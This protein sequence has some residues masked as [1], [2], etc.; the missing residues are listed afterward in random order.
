MKTAVPLLDDPRQSSLAMRFE[1][2]P[3]TSVSGIFLPS[4][5]IAANGERTDDSP[6]V[7]GDAQ[8]PHLPAQRSTAHQPLR[9]V[10][11]R[12]LGPSLFTTSS[13]SATCAGS[14]G[15]PLSTEG[16]ESAPDDV[17]G[18]LVQDSEA[19]TNGLSRH[20]LDA[21][22]LRGKADMPSPTPSIRPP[23]PSKEGS[24]S[25]PPRVLF[26]PLRAEDSLGSLASLRRHAQSAGALPSTIG[27]G[28]AKRAEGTISANSNGKG[29]GDTSGSVAAPPLI[30]VLTEE[31]CEMSLQM[32]EKAFEKADASSELRSMTSPALSAASHASGSS[33]AISDQ[34]WAGTSSMGS[35]VAG[36]TWDAPPSF[37]SDPAVDVPEEQME[38]LATS[39]HFLN[40]APSSPATQLRH[41]DAQSDHHP[42]FDMEALTLPPGHPESM[43]TT[44]RPSPRHPSIRIRPPLPQEQPM[45]RIRRKDP[46][47]A[48]AAR[49]HQ[50]GGE[51]E[52]R[53]ASTRPLTKT[54][55]LGHLPPQASTAF[56]MN[57]FGNASSIASCRIIPHKHCGFVTFFSAEVRTY[58][59]FLSRFVGQPTDGHHWTGCDVGQDDA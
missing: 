4:E 34:S 26:R 18:D 49:Y 1:A 5:A 11:R 12:A 3:A 47:Y 48:G 37:R 39:L 50:Q 15:R 10:I 20:A 17:K 32:E 9:E 59:F 25:S 42:A 41:H 22:S 56:L 2:D 6:R 7:L 14:D 45:S 19:A 52:G 38:V 44:R 53:P 13:E 30:R 28:M 55:W 24:A 21:S 16:A 58:F 46:Y 35:G 8:S 43:D 33:L 27:S 31:G 51:E 36:S 54:I 40:T 29:V 57:L 23:L